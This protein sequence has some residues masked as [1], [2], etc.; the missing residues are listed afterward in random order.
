[1]PPRAIS[2]PLFSHPCDGE[3]GQARPDARIGETRR[4]VRRMHAHVSSGA[5]ADTES[6]NAK[7]LP[8]E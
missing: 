4:C 2:H 5:A 3:P 8:N 1:M 6:R 7:A